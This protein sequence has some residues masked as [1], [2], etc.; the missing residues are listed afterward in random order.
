LSCRLEVGNGGMSTMEY[1]AHFSLW[2]LAKS[3]LIVGCDIRNLTAD[4]LAILSNAEVI[5]LN[6]DALGV[7]G[8]MLDNKTFNGTV[9]LWAAPMASGATAA[10]VLNTG[11][12]DVEYTLNFS[13][14]GAPE[15]VD[16]RDL[17]ARKDVGE[18]HRSINFTVP[19]HGVRLMLLTPCRKNGGRSRSHHHMHKQLQD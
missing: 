2:A 12:S 19:T 6:Q 10:L 15:C 13:D 14:V 5:A 9:E 17:W 7:Q 8:H 4:T 16:P 11:S 18:S 1:Q 3:P